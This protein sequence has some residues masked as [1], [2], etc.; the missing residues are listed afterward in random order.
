[1]VD[2]EAHVGGGMVETVEVVVEEDGIGGDGL[3]VIENPVA[4]LDG[5]IVYAEGGV[6]GGEEGIVEECVHD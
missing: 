6:G 3:E 5:E 1:M 4:A 2:G